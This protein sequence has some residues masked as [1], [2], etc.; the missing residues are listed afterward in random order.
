MGWSFACDPSFDKKAQIER[1]RTG[2]FFAEGYTLLESRVVGNRFWYLLQEPDGK[3]TLGVLLMAGGG[4]GMGWGYK[5]VSE[6]MGPCEKDC[7]LA[8]LK[9]ADE[10]PNDY[11]KEWRTEVLEFHARKSCKR[12][13]VAGLVVK[14]GDREYELIEAWGPRRGWKV[15][16]VTYGGYYRMPAAQLSRA[17]A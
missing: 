5:C 6:S 17:L 15:R 14:S 3:K 11:A 2:K 16:D 10:P 12:K 7:P 1:F 4:R 13:P 9:L 8:L